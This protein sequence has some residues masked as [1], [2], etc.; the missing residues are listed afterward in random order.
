[1]KTALYMRV[2]ARGG[3]QPGKVRFGTVV[4]GGPMMEI[5]L[6]AVDMGMEWNSAMSHLRNNFR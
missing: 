3:D 4:G 2:D 1:M 5:L 6:M